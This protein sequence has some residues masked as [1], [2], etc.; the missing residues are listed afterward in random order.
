MVQFLKYVSTNM[1]LAQGS[2]KIN[3]GNKT[4]LG[5]LQKLIPW[6]KSFRFLGNA[7]SKRV[8]GTF[9]FTVNIPEV[10]WRQKEWWGKSRLKDEAKAHNDQ[11]R[12]IVGYT[13]NIF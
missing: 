1:F 13:N 6:I 11:R 2:Y 3:Q 12:A 5:N 8:W 10:G 4:A 9:S 7:I